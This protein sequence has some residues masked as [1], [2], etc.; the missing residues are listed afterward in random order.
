MAPSTTRAI[1]AIK[2]VVVVVLVLV[3]VEEEEYLH[4]TIKTEVTKRLGHT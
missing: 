4:G 3:V 1:V 2:V